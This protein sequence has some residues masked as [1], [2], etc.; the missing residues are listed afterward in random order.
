[1]IKKN[2]KM[3]IITSLITLIPLIAGLI[4]WN[5]LPDK[6]ATH[7]NV[8]G[9]VD[10]WS[11]KA[12]AVF[13]LPAFLLAVHLICV[14]ATGADPKNRQVSNKMYALVLWICP[15]VSFLCGFLTYGHALGYKIE[16]NTI[17][18]LFV[19]IVFI[20]IGN[21]MPKTTRNYTMGIKVPWTL[22]SD[23]NWNK[24][25]RFAGMLWVAGGVLVLIASFLKAIFLLPVIIIVC[26]VLP[27]VY[28]YVYY[29]K[30]ECGKND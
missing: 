8:N 5:Q 7:W 28:S 29:K 15:V 3:I 10:G 19:G 2:K 27:M 22:N 4:M 16:V 26:A 11:S 20:L 6:M 23:E 30:Y 14:F 12:F 17:L 24:T 21:Y 1:M 13:G 25:H 9:E 18:P